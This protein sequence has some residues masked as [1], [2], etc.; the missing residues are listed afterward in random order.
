MLWTLKEIKNWNLSFS[1]QSCLLSFKKRH[2]K[3]LNQI[4]LY[5]TRTGLSTVGNALSV[6]KKIHLQYLRI[7]SC[8]ILKRTLLVIDGQQLGNKHF[9][10]G[11]DFG[12]QN[13]HCRL[14][15]CLPMVWHIKEQRT[16][17]SLTFLW[18]FATLA[19]EFCKNESPFLTGICVS[20][21]AFYFPA[22]GCLV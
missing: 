16:S 21:L 20:Y 7:Y 17:H 10:L 12:L 15:T 4:I 19:M 14:G 13:N 8:R 6:T 11:S 22:T 5:N 1:S 18:T 9:R 3:F 2:S